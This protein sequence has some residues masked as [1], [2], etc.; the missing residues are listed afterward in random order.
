L[1]LGQP[2]DGMTEAL[3]PELYTPGRFH[4]GSR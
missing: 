3:D 1:L 2:R 4:R